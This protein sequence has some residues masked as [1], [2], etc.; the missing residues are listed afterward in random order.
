MTDLYDVAIEE[1][2]HMVCDNCGAVFE[3]YLAMGREWVHDEECPACHQPI[4]INQRE[5]DDDDG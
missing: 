5:K 2:G 4:R 1:P 3:D